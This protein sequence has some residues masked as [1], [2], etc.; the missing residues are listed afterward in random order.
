MKIAYNNLLKVSEYLQERLNADEII[1]ESVCRY[2]SP[3]VLS[4]IRVHY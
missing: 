1:P 4:T 3:V 2:S